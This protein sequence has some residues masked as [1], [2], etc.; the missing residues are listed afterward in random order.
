MIG[1]FGF[2]VSES[3]IPREGGESGNHGSMANI[4][5]FAITGSPAFAGDDN[6][7]RI[8]LPGARYYSGRKRPIRDKSGHLVPFE[9]VGCAF[10][11]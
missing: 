4:P 7:V 10:W 2:L 3:V 8:G 1:M 11:R 6:T 5:R 9:S